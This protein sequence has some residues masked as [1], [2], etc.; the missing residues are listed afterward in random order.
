MRRLVPKSSRA[1]LTGVVAATVA[2]PGSAWAKPLPLLSSVLPAAHA[3]TARLWPRT[4]DG[5]E[6]RSIAVELG[7]RVVPE[8]GVAQ[9]ASSRKVEQRAARADTLRGR[10]IDTFD[11]REAVYSSFQIGSDTLRFTWGHM[12]E[13]F[14]GVPQMILTPRERLP[15]SYPLAPLAHW[16]VD[17]VW[18]T[19]AYLVFGCTF[20]SE[21][22]FA[23]EQ[24]ALW[25]LPSGRW[26]STPHESALY[27]RGFKL[28]S[29]LED[30]RTAVVSDEGAAVRIE[31]ANGALVLTPDQ[32]TWARL[33]REGRG[34]PPPP[35]RV[36]RRLE[37]VPPEA[38]SRLLAPL[39]AAFHESN[40]AVDSV[41]ILEVVRDPC[42]GHPGTA[43]LAR[44]VAPRPP[45]SGPGSPGVDAVM[46]S[47]LYAVFLA[48]RDLT[49]LEKRL[50]LFTTSRLGD[51]VVYFDLD[52]ADD[53]LLVYGQGATYGDAET[54]RGYACG[55]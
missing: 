39:L 17:A 7:Q 23:Q 55:K 13:E 8:T 27:H 3:R 19:G 10:R 54:Q 2:V 26:Y 53:A 37:T 34:V 14:G 50:D 30:W 1:W 46:N 38:R 41:Q 42:I 9:V 40:P 15:K 24:L 49:S 20:E 51:Y 11:P 5:F 18:Y 52:A 43:V 33:D 31:G 22:A 16:N 44:G 21:G 12:A 29:A 4:G 36:Q 25:H 45:L 35:R 6:G 28:R 48:D 47:E 32:G